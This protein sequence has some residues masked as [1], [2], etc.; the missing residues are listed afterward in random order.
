MCL[1]RTAGRFFRVNKSSFQDDSNKKVDCYI[2]HRNYI[3]MKNLATKEI[4]R[5]LE[6]AEQ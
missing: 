2:N 1:P 4:D 3:P 6:I 5:R